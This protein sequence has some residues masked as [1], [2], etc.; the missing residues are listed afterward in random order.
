MIL[1]KKSYDDYDESKDID[2][3]VFLCNSNA[4]VQEKIKY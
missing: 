2:I 1:Y 4:N 3:D